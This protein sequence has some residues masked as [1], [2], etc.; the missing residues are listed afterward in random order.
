MASWIWS[1]PGTIGHDWRQAS[2]AEQQAAFSSLASHIAGLV[3]LPL[4]DTASRLKPF[5]TLGLSAAPVRGDGVTL[6]FENYPQDNQSVEV[7]GQ[8]LDELSDQLKTNKRDYALNLMFSSAEA[9]RGIFDY[10]KLSERMDRLKRKHTDLKILLLVLL[11]E[12]TTNEKKRLRYDI[13]DGLHGQQRAR[14]L[15]DLVMVL[16]YD[17]HSRDQLDDDIIYAADN[18]GGIGFWAQS[19]GANNTVADTA[20][21]AALHKNFVDIRKSASGK[22]ICKLLCSTR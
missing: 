8:F 16:S 3:E 18:F 7:F 4:S 5:L 10:Q 15:R 2:R 1:C 21:S 11:Q 20:V 17:G 9:G 19:A 14:L 13:E 22:R 12:P 6:H